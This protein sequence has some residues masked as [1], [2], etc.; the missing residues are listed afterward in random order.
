MTAPADRPVPPVARRVPVTMVLHGE[1]RTD[2]YAWLRDKDDPE[3]VAYLKAEDAYADA[4]LG[5]TAPFQ[6][7][8]YDE[9]LARIKEDDQSVPYRLGAW[10]YYSR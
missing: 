3:V 10:L 7:A 1:S 6:Q 5:P 4:V 8:L 2:E 9:M